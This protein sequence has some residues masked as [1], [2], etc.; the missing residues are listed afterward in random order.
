MS[1]RSQYMYQKVAEYMNVTLDTSNTDTNATDHC[2]VND[3]DPHYI[4]QQEVQ[5]ETAN[6]SMYISLAHFLPSLIMTVFYGVYSDNLGRRITFI[7]PPIGS[8]CSTLVTMAMLTFDLPIQFFFL[9]VV[10]YLFGG[11]CIYSYL[12]VIIII[13]L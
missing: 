12:Y 4:L 13:T 1:I 10:E 2:K 7:L 8:I 3:S 5:A 9:E 6:W 11:K